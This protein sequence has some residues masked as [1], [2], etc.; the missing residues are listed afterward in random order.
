MKFPWTTTER[1]GWV[2]GIVASIATIAT[3][4]LSFHIWKHPEETSVP[5]PVI[6]QNSVDAQLAAQS[7]RTSAIS[8]RALAR[9]HIGNTPS[10]EWLAAEAEFKQGNEEYTKGEYSLAAT[11][12]DKAQRNFNDIY[13]SFEVAQTSQTA[14]EVAANHFA[15]AQASMDISDRIARLESYIKKLDAE[16]KNKN[17]EKIRSAPIEMGAPPDRL[18]IAIDEQ[19]KTLQSLRAEAQQQII[20]MM[21]K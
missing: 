8:F 21:G 20:Q 10:Q 13:S 9:N 19:I 12:F 17:D 2:F 1:M 16:I 3:A 15:Q 11:F 6:A 18:T 14:P 4:V 7:L 5:V